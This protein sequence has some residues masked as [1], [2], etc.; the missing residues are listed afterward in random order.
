MDLGAATLDMFAPHVGETFVVA[1]PGTRLELILREAKSLASRPDPERRA[2]FSL[3]FSGPADAPL[4]QRIYPL[5]HAE[6]GT[7][8]IFLV[9][10]GPSGA[11]LRYEAVFG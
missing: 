5:E 10:L 8:E 1:M 9:P 3:L 7:L 11:E 2:P 6:L 4:P